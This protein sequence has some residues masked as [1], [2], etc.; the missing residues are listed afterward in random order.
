[1]SPLVKR[2]AAIALV[3]FATVGTSSAAVRTGGAT[4][5]DTLKK[6][7][8]Y[9][10]QSDWRPYWLLM[11]PRFRSSCPFGKFVVRGEKARGMVG[12]ASVK[13]LSS[14]TTGSH[15]YLTYETKASQLR[16]FVTRDD[17]FVKIAGRW[18]DEIDRVTAC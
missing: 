17:L 10:N 7:V 18:Y 8:A 15:A 5:V 4:P 3:L 14:R 1:M 11:S 6:E 9:F 13:L 16:A 12:R 2:A